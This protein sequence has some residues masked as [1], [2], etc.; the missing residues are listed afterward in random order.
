[1]TKASNPHRIEILL[2]ALAM[3]SAGLLTLQHINNGEH[4][5]EKHTVDLV[6]ANFVT[7]VRTGSVEARSRSVDPAAGG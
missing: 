3:V 4:P 6:P 1:M 5:A 7:D 2:T